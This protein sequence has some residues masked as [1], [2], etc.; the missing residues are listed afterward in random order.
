MKVNSHICQ[1]RKSKFYFYQFPFVLEDLISIRF[2]N[3]T[4][5]NCPYEKRG[6]A[7]TGGLDKAG[8]FVL[9]CIKLTIAADHKFL[10]NVL[11]S[12]PSSKQLKEWW[13]PF[14]MIHVPGIKQKVADTVLH[15]PSGL[16]PRTSHTIPWNRYPQDDNNPIH[17]KLHCRP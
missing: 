13:F 5:I 14:N 17:Q 16:R 12:I 9:G 6:V 11:N 1:N 15:Y 3:R 4:E 2:T 8:F 10:V 7:V